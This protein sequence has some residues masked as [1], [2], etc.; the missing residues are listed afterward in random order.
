MKFD[1]L[2]FFSI[3]CFA[4]T[5]PHPD[6]GYSQ[7]ADTAPPYILKPYRISGLDS[8]VIYC[9][10]F[11]NGQSA[12]MTFK[13]VLP[14]ELCTPSNRLLVIEG[15]EHLARFQNLI[16]QSKSQSNH[17]DD[18]TDTRFV[19]KCFRK[20]STFLLTYNNDSTLFVD[21]KRE[22]ICPRPILAW[23]M[24]EM[25]LNEIDCPD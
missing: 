10:C 22:L 12:C 1:Y 16:N 2:F 9:W 25:N 17:L 19:I 24:S 18:F 21:E 6:P 13:R 20:D 23:I 4:C 11:K 3:L 5:A 8:A 15:F 14:Q 7:P